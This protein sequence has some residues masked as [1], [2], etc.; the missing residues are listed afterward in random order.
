M[1]DSSHHILDA[2]SRGKIG[3]QIRLPLSKAVEISVKALQVR[4]WR[5]MLTVSSIILA[6]AFLTFIWS[7]N[8][9]DSAVAVGMRG[10]LA[11]AAEVGRA[12]DDSWK[13][14][15]IE[16]RKCFQKRS[17]E[18]KRETDRL[19]VGGTGAFKEYCRAAA[20]D[21]KVERRVDLGGLSCD[22]QTVRKLA[23]L[24]RGIGLAP[25][26]DNWP[27]D[28]LRLAGVKGVVQAEV[29]RFNNLQLELQRRKVDLEASAEE[30]SRLPARVVWLIVISLM[31]C[32]GGITNAMLMSV[33]ERFREIGTMKCLGALD[34]F[35]VKLFLLESTFQGIVGTVL[36]IALGFVITL[37]SGLSAYGPAALSY[38]P[39]LQIGLIVV[40]ALVIGAVLSVLS[41]VFPALRAA[42]MAPVE[43]MRVEE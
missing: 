28:A 24:A 40:Y 3:K 38:F 10:D 37:A 23:A 6:I 7:V 31:V 41:A 29:N 11:R 19:L 36:G 21:P 14:F 26:L 35:I 32:G 20:S 12:V 13:P 16:L 30:L 2:P 4:F 27:V 5:S 18:Y 9:V 42:H 22:P 43:A 8:R 39:A 33:T 15:E 1:R 25:D 34:S 17:G